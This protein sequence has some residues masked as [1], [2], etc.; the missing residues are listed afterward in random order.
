MLHSEFF[1]VILCGVNEKST[2]PHVLIFRF[3]YLHTT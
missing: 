1:M 2:I 3:V